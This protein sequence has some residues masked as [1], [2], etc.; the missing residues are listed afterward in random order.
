ML[1]RCILRLG[2]PQKACICKRS[3]SGFAA[4]TYGDADLDSTTLE[5]ALR[6]GGTVFCGTSSSDYIRPYQL[7]SDLIISEEILASDLVVGHRLIPGETGSTDGWEQEVKSVFKELGNP[8]KFKGAFVLARSAPGLT[9]K[10]SVEATHDAVMGIGAEKDGLHVGVDM[11]PELLHS[12]ETQGGESAIQEAIS[13]ALTAG[14]TI[15]SV[16]TTPFTA[17]AAKVAVEHARANGVELVLAND[18]LRLHTRRPG[19]LS[20]VGRKG[21]TDVILMDEAIADFKKAL[22]ICMHAEKRYLDEMSEMSPISDATQ[23]CWGHVLAQAQGSILF[24][25]EWTYIQKAQAEPQLEEHHAALKAA[26]TQTREF[27]LLHFPLTK[28]L[29]AAFDR[30]LQA[31]KQHLVQQVDD[32]VMKHTDICAPHE[33]AAALMQTA[34]GADH[35]LLSGTSFDTGNVDTTAAQLRAL[36]PKALQMHIKALRDVYASYDV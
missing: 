9:I 26:G 13:E 3:A 30:V 22:D 20:A 12:L 19:Q 23:L 21:K 16:G 28:F 11:G 4:S 35:V 31:R 25:E 5:K 27:A 14:A 34:A 24:P 18:V 10:S 15:L 7:L 29:F 32:E 8:T 2:S 6:S 1:V 33:W 36:D 17:S